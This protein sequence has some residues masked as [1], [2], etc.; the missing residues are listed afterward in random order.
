MKAQA[1]TPTQ[2]TH[3]SIE[4]ILRIL[5]HRYPFLYVDRAELLNPAPNYP[6]R[7]GKKVKAI[8]NVTINEPFFVGH[9]PD[10]PVVPGVI[11]IEMVAQ[12]AI[13]ALFR[14]EDP[15]Q[16]VALVSVKEAKFR[17]PVIPGDQIEIIAEVIKDRGVM[18]AIRGE[19]F[20]REQLVAEAE[21]LAHM[22]NKR[23]P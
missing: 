21:I 23:K 12:A 14:P 7:T 2:Q 13:V 22:F 10:R 4:D 9:F 8:K 16:E 17:Q 20:V 6:V 5:P 1:P 15:P 11:L 18:M 3:F 19:L